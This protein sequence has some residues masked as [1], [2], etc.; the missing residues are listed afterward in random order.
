MI[1]LKKFIS[2]VFAVITAASCIVCASAETTTEPPETVAEIGITE[3]SET[4]STTISEESTTLDSTTAVSKENATETTTEFDGA[5][6][7]IV[8]GYGFVSFS[9]SGAN[10]TVTVVAVN[11]KDGKEYELK[12]EAK[13]NY[14]VQ[15]S[16][17][18]G[19]YTVKSVKSE[20]DGYKEKNLTIDGKE[21]TEFTV[22]ET[23]F[24]SVKLGVT[25]KKELFIISFLKREWFLLIA[26][27]ALVAAYWY[28]RTHRILPS[29]E[30]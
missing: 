12:F 28:K 1:N 23:D 19:Q 21:A 3:I 4:E 29:Q 11:N 8:N 14:I 2:I 27:I 26:L 25:E 24:M 6:P 20:T 13:N 10:T 22:E 18:V 5:T 30:T 9:L 15:N 17:P 7:I 16:Y